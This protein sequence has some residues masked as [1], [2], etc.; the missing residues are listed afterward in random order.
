MRDAFTVKA[1][2]WNLNHNAS[3]TGVALETHLQDQKSLSKN[4]C[5]VWLVAKKKCVTH[6][7]LQ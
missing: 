3:M 2:Y 6:E 4:S 5:F 7:N 1:G